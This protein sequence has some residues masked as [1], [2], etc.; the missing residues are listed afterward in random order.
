M[1]DQSRG[2]HADFLSS[3]GSADDTA[4]AAWE[5]DLAGD[6]TFQGDDDDNQGDHGARRERGTSREE[7]DET[8][9]GEGDEEF[10]L[11]G[12]EDTELD[13]DDPE[14][15]E[16]DEDDGDEPGDQ[17]KDALDP[18]T[19]VKVKADGEELEVTLEE[20]KSGYSRTQAWTR[21]TQELAEE[22]KKVYQ[23][24]AELGAEL[25]SWRQ[26][27]GQVKTHLEAQLSGRSE[28]E[29]ARLKQEDPHAYYEQRDAEYRIQ[30]RVKAA[31]EADQQAQSEQQK[32][33]QAQQRRV[34]AE[35]ADMLIS[36]L[37]EWSDK[38]VVAKER[39]QIQSYG[40]EMGFT[41]QEINSI[42]DH[43]VILALRDAAKYAQLRA[44]RKSGKGGDKITKGK[45]PLRA[46]TPQ[47][48]SSSKVKHRKAKQRLQ[49]TGTRAAASDYFESLLD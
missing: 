2:A 25:D 31:Q 33:M 22:R 15:D 37:P 17:T 6:D 49:K 11:E 12:D 42:A 1:A 16:D 14:G 10:D 36:K 32:I 3:L 29:W 7:D 19:K 4:A 5:Q 20:L 23:Q 47:N 28:Q 8:T 26:A 38:E 39:A 46:G 27:I 9:D 43:R 18:K 45:K 40:K 34:A 44:S 35:Q 30:E 24:Q 48:Q 21:K 41:D 13:E